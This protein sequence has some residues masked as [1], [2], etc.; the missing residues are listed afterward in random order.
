MY[1]L[2]NFER[3]SAATIIWSIQGVFLQ[4]VT[5]GD[6]NIGAQQ[7]QSPRIP[8]CIDSQNGKLHFL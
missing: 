8:V 2:K 4:A 6:V 7:L 5:F 1:D 3:A